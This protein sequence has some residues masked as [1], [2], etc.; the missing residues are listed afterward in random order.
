MNIINDQRENVIT[1]NNIAQIQLIDILEG[2]SKR[3]TKLLLMSLHGDLDFGQL[4]ELGFVLINT[5]ILEEGEITSISNIPEGI[6]VLECTKN[7]LVSLDNLP[8]SLI[9]LNVSNNYLKSIDVSELTR[10]EKL[11]ISHNQISVL[12][13]LPDSLKEIRCENNNLE[14]LDFKGLTNL[15]ILNISSNSVTV[16]D[17]LPENIV[18][19]KMDN[20]PSI[21][22]RNSPNIPSSKPPAIVDGRN[23]LE[24][25]ND[26]LRL[27]NMYEDKIYKMKKKIFDNEPNKKI[28]KRLVLQL[29]PPCVNCKRAVGTIFSKKDYR[30]EAICGDAQTP[31]NLNIQIFSG[32]MT[33]FQY[34]LKLFKEETDNIKEIIIFQKLDTIF[35]YVSE[36]ISIALFKKE[37][38]LYNSNSAYYKQFLDKY[39]DLYNNTH[40]NELIQKK[41]NEVFRLIEKSR[42][43]LAEYKK[44]NE[45]EHLRLAVDLHVNQLIPETRNLR[46][47]KYGVME[48]I[49]T[50]VSRHD[51]FSLFQF[52]V[53]LSNLDYTTAEPPRVIKYT[54]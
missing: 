3:S 18:D 21:D 8:S 5:I 14:H 34:I 16:I 10:L 15:K 29:K 45:R 9:S 51:V 23:Y 46:M 35:G 12:E 6:T 27:K 22:F 48:I 2:Y 43:L 1:E 19:F 30:Y 39:N 37:L 54:R 20:N 7:L 53:P 4:R 17:N 31:C 47:M 50:E 28:A 41:Q 52:L 33:P 38:A 32:S 44:T 26:Y 42:G 36:D 40:K 49:K 24:S 13:N 25:L 11:N